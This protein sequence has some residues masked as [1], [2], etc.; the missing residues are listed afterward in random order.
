MNGFDIGAAIRRVVPRVPGGTRRACLRAAICGVG[1]ACVAAPATGQDGVATLRGE[2]V[3]G[4]G[5]PLGGVRVIARSSALTLYRDTRTDRGGRYLLALLPP[6]EYVVSFE[7]D[8]L[9]TTRR[10]THLS[11]LE[12]STAV[13]VMASASNADELIT[14]EIDPDEVLQEPASS[15]VTRR[16]WMMRLP[17]DGGLLTAMTLA[18]G[19]LGPEA[20][21][22]AVAIDGVPVRLHTPGAPLLDPGGVAAAETTAVLSGAPPALSRFRSGVIDLV[23]LRGGTAP[24][25][26]LLGT[27]TGA[28][29]LADSVDEAGR[30][31]SVSSGAEFSVSV[32]VASRRTSAFGAGRTFSIP[33]T[34]PAL[35]SDAAFPVDTSEDYWAFSVTH[36]LDPRHRVTG[37]ASRGTRVQRGALPPWA[38]SAEVASAGEDRRASHELAPLDYRGTLGDNLHL[39]ARLTRE[40]RGVTA[41]DTDVGDVLLVLDRQTGAATGPGS[42]CA[43]QPDAQALTSWSA[44][45]RWPV[46]IATQPHEL[47]AGVRAERGDVTFPGLRQDV[48]AVLAT[49]FE[50]DAGVRPI[51][52]GNGSAW[53]VRSAGA[54]GRLAST[55]QGLFVSDAW[56]PVEGL[57]VH[58]GAHWDRQRLTHEPTGEPVVTRTAFGPRLHATWR[59]LQED[60]WMLF[61]GIG[62]VE[63]DLL[64][65]LGRP[66]A[67][68]GDWFAYDGGADT[69]PGG[70]SIED[71]LAWLATTPGTPRF[72]G[73][74]A[75]AAALASRGRTALG[76]TLEWTVGSRR[77]IGEDIHIELD[78]IW[79][80]ARPLDDPAAAGGPWHAGVPARAFERPD[81]VDLGLLTR[82]YTALALQADY[83]LGLQAGLSAI[84][85]L[86][87]TSG[88]ATAA[89]SAIPAA[90]WAAPPGDL[91]SDRRHRLT[92]WTHLLPFES[93]SRG[94]LDL[95]LLQTIQSGAPYGIVSWID[96]APP[97]SPPLVLPYHF[98][99]RD[100]LRGK[101][102]LR[103]DMAVT[104]SKLMPGTLRTRLLVTFHA[105]NLFDKERLRD[106]SALHAPRTAF[107]H[108]ATFARFDPF[109]EVPQQGTHWD[110]DPR[111]AE[112]RATGLETLPRSFLLS[113]GVSF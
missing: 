37:A 11:P 18:P 49:R 82:R 73:L 24:A 88:E 17:R 96:A 91:S 23:T 9:V 36:A 42:A 21:D 86:S 22:A 77:H 13:T 72:S 81:A 6:G 52:E 106:P 31:R 41:L 20:L 65:A 3:D 68:A 85:T 71:A 113:A 64:S 95:T 35:L 93:D 84:Y 38:V 33:L 99:A 39:S 45:L 55:A 76:P 43:C 110:R 34:A 30:T 78:L 14:V 100:A 8:G 48:A 51:L 74:D 60:E 12:T 16:D 70:T 62:R 57:T 112:R 107:T 98:T 54:P 25:A 94:T 53:I 108:P 1:L 26:I 75:S 63:P 90:A 50:T 28:D 103:T 7:G 15:S 56:R 69:P 29:R 27:L 47:A 87:R 105:L 101:M 67:P 104:Y 80:R 19:P 44:E 111:L 79:R 58:A 4:S 2:V 92:V 83:D 61:G 109:T 97:G 46:A 10:T 102:A 59:P 40:Q 89:A 5:A 32:P 66:M